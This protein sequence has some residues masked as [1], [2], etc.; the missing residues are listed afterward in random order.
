MTRTLVRIVSA[1]HDPP[2]VGSRWKF[3]GQ[4]DVHLVAGPDQSSNA[5]D[6][7]DT[8]R[9]GTRA[10]GQDGR[11]KATF[12]ERVTSAV[13]N[14]APVAMKFLTKAPRTRS[15]RWANQRW[16]RLAFGPTA[17]FGP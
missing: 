6:L 12:T 14:G 9:H 1:R 3:L 15:G 17:R 4:N 16:P 13:R 8:N 5:G 10:R 2:S 7:I 11:Q